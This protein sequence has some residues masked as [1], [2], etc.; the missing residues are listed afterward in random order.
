MGTAEVDHQLAREIREVVGERI[1]SERGSGR[2][3]SLSEEDLRQ[4]ALNLVDVEIEARSRARMATGQEAIGED[5]WFELRAEIAARLF[6]AG[7]LQ[8]LLDDTDIENIDINGCDTV[9]IT[10]ADGQRVAGEPVADSDTELVEEIQRLASYEGLSARP[11]DGANPELDLRL[12]DG[13]RLSAVMRVATRPIVSLRRHRLTKVFL[14]DLVA[15]GTLRPPLAAFLE[16]MVRS[17]TNIMVAGETDS[18]KTTLLRALINAIDPDE[19]LATV[20]NSRELGLSQL[21]DLHP[22]VIE[23]EYAPPNAEGRGEVTM[24][25]LVRRTLRHNADRVIVGEVLGPEVVT[26]LNAMSQGQGGSLST[27]HARTPEG[28]FH[29]VATYARQA[30]ERLDVETTHMLIADALHFVVFVEKAKPMS[31]AAPAGARR[32]VSHVL[33]INGWDTRVQASTIWGPGPDRR[34]VRY[35]NVHIQHLDRLIAAGYDPDDDLSLTA[36][37]HHEVEPYG[38]AYRAGVSYRLGGWR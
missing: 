33:E 23:L 24:A 30:E 26:M 31:R 15:N 16:A 9:F 25:Q 32:Y 14:A 19:R 37:P 28:V 5:E 3:G 13:T 2:L 1:L 21:P 6:G 7:R 38:A 8:R 22:N 12:R 4:Y 34:A 35:P 10:Y 20:E 11:F 27:I 29:R 17:R 18:G 36:G